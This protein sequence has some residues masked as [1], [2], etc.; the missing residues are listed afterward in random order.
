MRPT[1]KL[2]MERSKCGG[3]GTRSV[4]FSPF[5]ILVVCLGLNEVFRFRP[6][7]TKLVKNRSLLCTVFLSLTG[8]PTSRLVRLLR[9]QDINWHCSWISFKIIITS[10]D[11][12]A[13]LEAK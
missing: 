4:H 13:H 3:T 10:N 8:K 6:D 2:L 12:V 11:H 7:F 1:Y 5:T 9:F